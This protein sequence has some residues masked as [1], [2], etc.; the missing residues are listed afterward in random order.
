M[1]GDID[2][3]IADRVMGWVCQ[4]GSWLEE[5]VGYHVTLPEFSTKIEAA[6]EVVGAYK[7]D[8]FQISCREGDYMAWFGDVCSG[9]QETAP[10]A[11]CI[12]AL[13]VKGIEVKND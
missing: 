9:W 5:A 6:W 4:R 7:R 2:A 1:T 10:M 11:I 12:A 3:L 8:H 13:K